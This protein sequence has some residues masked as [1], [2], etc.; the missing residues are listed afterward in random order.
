MSLRQKG[1]HELENAKFETFSAQV[2]PTL[3]CQA[4]GKKLFT[5][6]KAQNDNILQR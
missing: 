4:D 3:P 6:I 1:E 2:A 5:F